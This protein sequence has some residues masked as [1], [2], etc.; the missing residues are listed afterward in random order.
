MISICY[1]VLLQSAWQY[2]MGSSCALCFRHLHAGSIMRRK[3]EPCCIEVRQ[4]EDQI[5][6]GLENKSPDETV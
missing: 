6:N 1:F 5:R 4:Q 2:P 3:K